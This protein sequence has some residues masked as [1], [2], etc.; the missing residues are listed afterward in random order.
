VY[1]LGGTK[2]DGNQVRE[3]DSMDHYELSSDSWTSLNVPLALSRDSSS[4]AVIYDTL[5]VISTR[6]ESPF[7]HVIEFDTVA[8]MWSTLVPLPRKL[9][10]PVH[11]GLL[12]DSMWHGVKGD[13][14]AVVSDIN[15]IDPLAYMGRVTFPTECK[16]RAKKNV[17]PPKGVCEVLPH[18]P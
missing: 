4:V 16:L 1:V 15:T 12:S 5:A 2:S 13:F 7:S 18:Q 14:I 11:F 9:T 8:D 3:L 17:H 6:P 10:Q